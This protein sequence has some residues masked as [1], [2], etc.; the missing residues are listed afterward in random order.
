MSGDRAQNGGSALEKLPAEAGSKETQE[1][2]R[3]G[4][5]RFPQSPEAKPGQ[6]L[7]LVRDRAMQGLASLL[8]EGPGTEQLRE[9]SAFR[10]VPEPSSLQMARFL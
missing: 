4:T 10:F 5:S 8:L 7:P 6:L 3:R 2:A 1:P 9:K